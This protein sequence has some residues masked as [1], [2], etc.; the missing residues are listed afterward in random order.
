MRTG[1]SGENKFAAVG[2]TRRHVHSRELFIDLYRFAYI[3]KVEFRVDA[4][5]VHIKRQRDYVHVSRTLA[6]AEQS[7]LDSVRTGKQCRFRIG[8][9]AASVVVRVRGKHDGVAVRHMF[10]H[11][12]DLAGVYVRHT[13]R[14]RDGQ[15]DNSLARFFRFPNVEYGVANVECVFGF[16]SGKTFGRIFETVIAAV[17]LCEA[18]EHNRSVHG[19]FQ[20][21]CLGLVENLFAL[22]DRRRVV[23]MNDCVFNALDCLESFFDYVFAALRQNLNR[24]IVGD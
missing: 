2:L 15:I 13:V 9:S 14:Y 11:I 4:L 16:R 5:T 8:D 22:C 23:E 20:N 10:V 7:A 3:R 17:L 6:V 24:H 21:I 12:F 19:Y 18:V 1:K